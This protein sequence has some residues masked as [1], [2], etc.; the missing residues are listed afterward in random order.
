[1]AALRTGRLPIVWR[2]FIV[3]ACFF[4]IGLTDLIKNGGTSSALA[5]GETIDINSATLSDLT[6][7]TMVRG[8]VLYCMG[9]YATE[10]YREDNPTDYYYS[11]IVFSGDDA[12]DY[13]IATIHTLRSDIASTLDTIADETIDYWIGEIDESYPFTNL[14][15]TGRVDSLDSEIYSYLIEDLE[16]MGLTSEEIAQHVSRNEI[17]YATVDSAARANTTDVILLV[18][19]LLG[20]II[21]LAVKYLIPAIASKRAEVNYSMNTPTYGTNNPQDN[22]FAQQDGSSG[23]VPAYQPQNDGKLSPEDEAQLDKFSAINSSAPSADDFFA[24]M[25]RKSKTA[26]ESDSS[27]A[28]EVQSQEPQEDKNNA[29]AATGASK[30]WEMD[31]LDTSGLGIGIDDY[32][33]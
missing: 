21:I 13:Y 25:G 15:I 4:I 26:A 9:L 12:D 7:G 30:T 11:I 16:Y 3:A 27:A 23:Y 10:Y 33:E 14:Y 8:D 17:Y 2:I 5:N 18:V 20:M 19:G 32:E 24:D 31:S 6:T 22:I 29:A 1:M 28:A